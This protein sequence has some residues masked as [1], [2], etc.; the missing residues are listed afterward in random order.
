[1]VE[2]FTTLVDLLNE[3]SPYLLLGF[4][5][6]GLLHSFVPQRTYARHLSGNGFGAAIKAA[7]IGIPL[8]LCSCGVIPTT[9]SLR[10]N[11]ASQAASTSFLIATPQTGIDSIA[12]TYSLLGLPFAIARPLIA[13]VTAI[14]GGKIVGAFGDETKAAVTDDDDCCEGD[15]CSCGCGDDCESATEMS[16]AGKLLDAL[17]YGFVHIMQD[18]GRWL[19]VGLLLAALITVVVP[20]GFFAQF[21][22]R[23]LL[24]ML[25]VLCIAAPMYICATG[26][27]PVALSFMLKGMSPGAALVLLMAGPATNVMSI[28]VIGRVFGRRSLLLYLLSIVAGAIG[29]GLIIDYMLPLEWFT[30]H[31]APVGDCACCD[32][33][34]ACEEG[35]GVFS[36]ICS[37]A[38]VSMLAWSFVRLRIDSL[39]NKKNHNKTDMMKKEFKVKGMMCNHCKAN[40]ETNLAKVPGVISVRVDL[41]SGIAYVEGDFNPADVVDMIRSL[42]YEYVE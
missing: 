33:C 9:V 26:S 42:G 17:E 40:V 35:A 3:M 10:K 12:A 27:I 39:R 1:M 21:A 11:G 34:G 28:V 25:I 18:V 38:F 6:A 14:F 22:D 32:V 13:F 41:A 2:Y 31:L 29:F 8:P 7:L 24:N 4:F 20:E 37:V 30:A 19:V 23:P 5:V 15:S 16:F 36:V